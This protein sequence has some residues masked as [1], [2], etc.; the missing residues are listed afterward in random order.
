VAELEQARN[1][2]GRTSLTLVFNDSVKKDL[3]RWVEQGVFYGR[4]EALRFLFLLGLASV[5]DETNLDLIYESI[6]EDVP[7]AAQGITI[8]FAKGFQSETIQS[9]QI[10][11]RGGKPIRFRSRRELAKSMISLGLTTYKRLPRFVEKC[12]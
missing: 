10:Y 5:Q 9:K 6:N 2:R 7:P 12:Q 1:E 4:G 11:R 8:V 3:D